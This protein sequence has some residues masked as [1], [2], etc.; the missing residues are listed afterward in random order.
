M[1]LTLPGFQI[2]T[3]GLGPQSQIIMRIHNHGDRVTLHVSR[4]MII[5]LPSSPHRLLL[6]IDLC[7]APCP[8]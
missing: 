8:L 3:Q 4:D 5:W 7:V 2:T 6:T 1:K